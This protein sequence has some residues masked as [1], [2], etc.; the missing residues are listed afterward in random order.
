MHKTSVRAIGKHKPI[1]FRH[2]STALDGTVC[3]KINKTVFTKLDKAYDFFGGIWPN[4]CKKI[5]IFFLQISTELCKNCENIQ[6][7]R[8]MQKLVKNAIMHAKT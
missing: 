3:H 5:K 8:K 4:Y 7:M 2:L 1:I 6:K